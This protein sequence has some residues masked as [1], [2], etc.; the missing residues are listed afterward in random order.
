MLFSMRGFLEN[1]AGEDSGFIMAMN[2]ILFKV[3]VLFNV[4]FNF[5]ETLNC[6]LFEISLHIM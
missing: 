4:N 5:Y 2:G 3:C 1:L 6:F